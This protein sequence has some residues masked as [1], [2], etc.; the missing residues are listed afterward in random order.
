MPLTYSASSP[1]IVASS[2]SLAVALLP[3]KGRGVIALH[4]LRAGE[5]VE[6]APVIVADAAEVER[7]A[8]T[9]LGR[10]YYEWG[11]SE[12]QAAIALGYG[13]LYNHSY[14]PNLAYEFREEHTCIDYIALR[15]IEAGEELTINYNNLGDL[16]A[17]PLNF[18]P[19]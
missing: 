8:A 2:Q 5:L 3:S 16:A 9:T 1:A 7:I 19:R 11:A 4:A 6:R 18:D 12:D 14:E 17:E 15:D 13:S 10:Y